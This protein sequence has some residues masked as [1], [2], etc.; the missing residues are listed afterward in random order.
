MCVTH[1]RPS[2][3]SSCVLIFLRLDSIP[4]AHSDLHTYGVLPMNLTCLLQIDLTWVE[5][6]LCKKFR[7]ISRPGIDT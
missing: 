3:T 4:K 6:H 7:D 2:L 5:G 1:A